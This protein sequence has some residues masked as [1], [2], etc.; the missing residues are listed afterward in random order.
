MFF[1]LKTIMYSEI[2]LF[3]TTVMKGR[4]FFCEFQNKS[5][6]IARATTNLVIVSFLLS[7]TV[8]NI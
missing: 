1:H 2:R 4:N 3:F 6:V 5:H 7:F 8:D